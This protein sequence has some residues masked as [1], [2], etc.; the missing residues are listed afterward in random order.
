MWAPTDVS[1]ELHDDHGVDLILAGFGEKRENTLVQVLV[2]PFG[3]GAM[4]VVEIHYA[5]PT[6]D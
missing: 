1:F 3:E 6:S 2:E 5:N 4:H